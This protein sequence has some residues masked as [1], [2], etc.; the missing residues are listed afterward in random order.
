M[1]NKTKVPFPRYLNAK[2]LFYKWEYD[3][4]IAGAATFA[5][6]FFLSIW[7]TINLL[8]GFI[9]SGIIS[10]FVTKRYVEFFKKTRRGYISHLG[11]S[12]GY[13]EPFAKKDIKESYEEHLIPKG[14]ENVFID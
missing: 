10:W 4:V 8:I 1:A 13:K 3:V 12:K 6:L 7:L 5:S 9:G 2:K 14:F 11:Y